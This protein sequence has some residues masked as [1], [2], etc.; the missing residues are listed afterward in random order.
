MTFAN[1]VRRVFL[2]LGLAFASLAVLALIIA[3]SIRTNFVIPFRWVM[4][5]AFTALLIWIE[6][7]TYRRYWSR[8]IFWLTVAVMLCIHLAVFI[9]IL[10]NYP[11]FRPFWLAPATIVEAGAFG[12][13]C[14]VLLD[15]SNVSHRRKPTS[16]T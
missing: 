12:A 10:R 13:I 1:V 9:A 11:G 6:I 3:I 14:G 5:V 15:G 8:P 16:R 4:L 2:Y 7:K